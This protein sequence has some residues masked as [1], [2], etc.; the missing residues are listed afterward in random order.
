MAVL[1]IGNRQEPPPH[2]LSK[3]RAAVTDDLYKRSE[4]EKIQDWMLGGP[5]VSVARIRLDI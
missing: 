4:A 2:L 3:D 5:V 1:S